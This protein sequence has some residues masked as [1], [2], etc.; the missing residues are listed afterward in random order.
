MNL[1]NRLSIGKGM[2]ACRNDIMK[3][4]LFAEPTE[5]AQA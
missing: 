3:W 5:E 4:D 2:P 1:P